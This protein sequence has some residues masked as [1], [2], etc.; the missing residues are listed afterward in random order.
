MIGGRL[1]VPDDLGRTGG[2][3]LGR[4]HDRVGVSVEADVAEEVEVVFVGIGGLVRGQAGG[5]RRDVGFDRRRHDRGFSAV[6]W[7]GKWGG[8]W[9]PTGARSPGDKV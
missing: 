2:A 8:E 6:V 4:N 5:E 1:F 9:R 3:V 7:F